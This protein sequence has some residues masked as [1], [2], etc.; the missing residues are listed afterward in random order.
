MPSTPPPGTVTPPDPV[1]VDPPAITTTET[2][3][4]PAVIPAPAP[5]PPSTVLEADDPEGIIED[6]DHVRVPTSKFRELKAKAERKGRQTVEQR[7]NVILNANGFQ[8]LDDMAKAFNDLKTKIER[9]P[10]VTTPDP[11]NPPAG[12]PAV[13]APPP[14]ITPPAIVAPLPG[15]PAPEQRRYDGDARD[16]IRKEKERNAAA[17]ATA[18]AAQQTA[19]AERDK[20]AADLAAFRGMQSVRDALIRA[21]CVDPDYALGRYQKATEKLKPEELEK[22]DLAAWTAELQKTTP[23]LFQATT[24]TQPA[25]TGPTGAPPPPNPAQTT[26]VAT[27]A[28]PDVRNMSPADFKKW[29]A[30]QGIR[31]GASTS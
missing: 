30:E 24:V 19:I 25:Q 3:P 8:S 12:A 15:A 20:A 31:P 27:G 22:F 17:L 5:P 29:M 16:R 6:G 10:D 21:N 23:F 11:K 14:V 9:I 18:T 4:P 26:E 28:K 2:P 13:V 1:V 7:M